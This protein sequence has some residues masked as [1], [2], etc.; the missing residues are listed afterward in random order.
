MVVDYWP[1]NMVGDQ[2]DTPDKGGDGM[3]VGIVF[4]CIGC[5][6]MGVLVGRHI[7]KYKHEIIEW[8]K[9]VFE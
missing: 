4:L 2:D 9:D 5:F 3:S 8:I 7:T 1:I 6:I